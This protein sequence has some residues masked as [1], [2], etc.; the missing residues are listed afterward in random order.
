MIKA[1]IT[2]LDNTLIDT[3]SLEEI[4]E[5]RKWAS[6]KDNLN[7]CHIFSDVV[8]LIHSAKS[9]GIKIA[10][11]T[12]SPSHYAKKLLS[13]FEIPYDCLVTYHDV[14]RHKPA[15]DG[16]LKI[17]EELNVSSDQAIYLG[18]NDLDKQSAFNADV[19]FFGVDWGVFRPSEIELGSV[20]DL[21]KLIG[22]Q[23][24]YSDDD[25][26]FSHLIRKE[27]YLHL[28]Y[29]VST[30]KKEVWDFKDGNQDA[31]NRWVG[32]T[33][34]LITEFPK[35]DVVVRALG[36]KELSA[37]DQDDSVPL[38][39][40]SKSLASFLNAKYEPGLIRKNKE[41]D[42]STGL[43][44]RQ[45]QAQ[46]E[47][48]YSVDSIDARNQIKEEAI[49]LIVDDVL[50]TGATTL[51]IKRAILAAFPS[52]TV[53]IFS[54]VKTIFRSEGERESSEE[55]H[56]NQ[57]F[58]DLYRL[59]TETEYDAL[60]SAGL[61]NKSFTANY[62]ISNS[63]FYIQNLS[64]SSIASRAG[65][66]KLLN[67]IKVAKNIIQRG[68]PTVASRYLRNKYRINLEDTG[69]DDGVA[70]PLISKL[71][72]KWS[73]LIRGDDRNDHNPAAY[74]FD[75]LLEKNLGD[76]KF[77]K[78]LTVPEVKVFDITQA[79]VDQFLNKQVDFYI[80]Q[81]G[82]IIEIDGSQH[83]DS[84]GEDLRRDFLLAKHG[85]K[86][87]R[88]TVNELYAEDES[89]HAKFAEIRDLCR[90]IE[91]LENDGL[92]TPPGGLT[93]SGY[94]CAFENDANRE[95][96]RYKLTSAIRLQLLVLELIES[97][98][99]RIDI[100]A[101]L[102]LLNRDSI[103]FSQYAVLDL[104]ELLDNIFTLMG[105][106]S[107][108]LDLRVEEVD[109][110]GSIQKPNS[111]N[112]D[113]SIFQ[114]F[115][116]SF[117]S[118][119]D[120]VFVRTHYIDF[121]RRYAKGDALNLSAFILEEYDFFEISTSNPI[122][123]KI[124]SDLSSPQRESLRYFLINLFLPFSEDADFREG[125]LG[126]IVSALGRNG[127]IGLLPT[128]SGKSICYQL[129]AI[130]QPSISF[131]VCP[132]KSLMYDQKNDLDAIGFTRTNYITSD[133]N[134]DE[135]KWIQRDY[136]RGR[137]FFV[138]VSPERFQ[139][140]GFRQEMSAINLDHSF[141]YAVIDEVHCLS[142]WGHDF[143]TSY[144][145]LANTINRFS[146]EASYIGL[147]ATASVNVLKDI[148]TEFEI[149]NEFVRTPLVFTR[150]ELSFHVIDDHG[151][152]QDE[153]LTLVSCLEDKW[154]KSSDIE[155]S[156][157]GIIFTLFVN[158]ESGCQSVAARLSSA[159]GMDVRYYSGS[160]PNH[161]ALTGQAFDQYKREVQDDFKSDKYHLLAAT[162]AFG[163]GVNKGNIA[164]TIHYGIP[165][166]MEALYQEA[167]RA[168]RDK[169]LFLDVPAD[170][171]VLLSKEDN[172]ED[173]QKIW[174]DEIDPKDLKERSSKLTR[175]SDI[176]A[177]M[178]LMNNGVES[179]NDEY[180]LLEQIRLFLVNSNEKKVVASASQFRT[181][182]FKFEK[183]IY[184]LSQLG[185]VIDWT[186]EDFFAGKLSIEVA[187]ISESD[188]LNNLVTL[189][190]KY[191]SDFDLNELRNS[192][193]SAYQWI[194]KKYDDKTFSKAQFSLLILLRW[195][196]DHFVYNRRQSLKTVYEQC[197]DLSS[198][199][200]DE[201]EFKNRL[202][203]YFKFNESSSLIH[204][205]VENTNNVSQWLS[206]FYREDQTSLLGNDELVTVK[207]QLSRFLESYKDNVFLDY[208]SGV[209]RLILDQFD[210]SDGERRMS[211]SLD[212]LN[213]RN[214]AEIALIVRETTK[215]KT[216]F[217]EEAK[218]RYSKLIDVKF[219][220]TYQG[221]LE[222]VNSEFKD[223]YSYRALINPLVR[224]IE[225]SNKLFKGIEW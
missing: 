111:V 77:L 207:E 15:P 213:K 181:D 123:Y 175:N 81:I 113:F 64:N 95:D 11:F 36:H 140:S 17:L 12:N 112:V 115:D 9:I 57:L 118:L 104:I 62:S 162:K 223:P 76:Y 171:Y 66:E 39:I 54:L 65:S 205:H 211:S 189:I 165:G 131:V 204:C 219:G 87:I 35:I 13:H 225:E 103:D 188:I 221:L 132:I 60:G 47:G 49:F 198:N 153:L 222:V 27:E 3:S 209:F 182:K 135:K 93:L 124:S 187:D 155:N 68:K 85:L 179:L 176:N 208:L 138:F 55:R 61:I 96:C 18:D 98:Q 168:G 20:N 110:F 177:N 203:G 63:N 125:Q 134:A 14:N 88:F 84:S 101:T 7:S 220:S 30:I 37:T 136:G 202:E 170:C 137:Y 56:N 109:S 73:R 33:K 224:K 70:L 194:Y 156:R 142:E 69:F 217:S 32:K 147:T 150:E 151:R 71:P 152:K 24:K 53:F 119:P 23:K 107:S 216:L 102:F 173:L 90:T 144:L 43:N 72:V 40:L 141:A 105:I 117:Q 52:A 195:S 146:P 121:Y 4:R 212:R 215:L 160:A 22:G 116:D 83:L 2:D 38:S 82:L 41:L 59:D 126:I 29:Y 183:A 108:S 192:T 167:G 106:K 185:L 120:I 191:D 172:E 148:Q 174:S 210:D 169:R 193:K 139:T 50:T 89:F 86:V 67:A 42:K 16:V 74:F 97:E 127:T 145:N 80:C 92:I 19:S 44:A 31:L 178:F 58:S 10:V 26:V 164:Y 51:D 122:E 25:E 197:I 214:P 130:L 21:R 199:E 143:R 133:L 166:S 6:V 186:I 161:G 129:A 157:A 34:S 200:I 163:M 79:Y 100:P 45:R 28:G 1:I 78:Q 201:I 5:N 128:G 159:L 75:E 180:V 114:R 184:R 48:V 190:L 206:V 158:G 91:K 149:P 218:I 154:G 94:K 46:V 8:D 99:I 196:Y